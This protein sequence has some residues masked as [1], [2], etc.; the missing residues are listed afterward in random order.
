ML[1]FKSDNYYQMVVPSL[2]AVS[3]MAVAPISENIRMLLDNF[4]SVV[5]QIVQ[6]L[7]GYTGELSLVHY[8]NYLDFEDVRNNYCFK[9]ES[10]EFVNIVLVYSTMARSWRIH[11]HSSPSVP[12]IYRPN[13]TARGQLISLTQVAQRML[14][15][16]VVVNKNTVGLQRMNHDIVNL[17]DRCLQSGLQFAPAILELEDASDA[18]DQDTTVKNYQM[19]DTGNRNHQT[20]LNKRYRELQ[21]KLNNVS[22]KSLRFYNDFYLDGGIRKGRYVYVTHHDIDPLSPTYGQ[23]YVERTLVDPDILPVV[24]T[25][26]V[27]VLAENAEDTDYWT[28]DNSRFPD[29]TFWK[30]R[31]PVTGKGY[32]PRLVLISK[33]ESMFELLDNT[34]VFKQMF[35]R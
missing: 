34:W 4:S 21:F 27:T 32:T 13:A 30:I 20:T 31:V 24:A 3:S 7:Y 22:K 15:D 17:A 9:L 14:I 18:P 26:G 35:S 33:N 23:L 10:G 2:K 19:L 6:E 16:G 28:L 11:A 5:G 12:H 25:P 1:F 8:H 29:I